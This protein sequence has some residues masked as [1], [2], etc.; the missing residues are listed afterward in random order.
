MSI[1]VDGFAHVRL[2]VT[3]ISCSRAFYDQVFAL[4]VAFEVPT[5]A[6]EETRAWQSSPLRHRCFRVLMELP[7]SPTD[8]AEGLAEELLAAVGAG[9]DGRTSDGVPVLLH[10]KDSSAWPALRYPVQRRL[11]T[12]IGLEDTLLLPDRSLAPGNAAMVTA[13][14]ALGAR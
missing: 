14:E 10:G 3:D 12:R 5:D 7:D 2:T 8:T 4:P 1:P 13:V 6:V 9:R 11:D